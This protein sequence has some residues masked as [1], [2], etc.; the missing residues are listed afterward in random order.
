MTDFDKKEDDNLG[1]FYMGRMRNPPEPRRIL[2]KGMLTGV[3]VFAFAAILWYAYPSGQEKFAKLDIPTITADKSAYKF[4]PENP[5]G[6]EVPHQ[7]STVFDPIDN[8][9]ADSSAIQKLGAPPEEPVDRDSILS[10]PPIEKKMERLNLDM[11]IKE[12]E[13]GTEKVV[14]KAEAL[15]EP[16]VEAKAE[17]KVE[18][19]AELKPE[20]KA[21]HP[22]IEAKPVKKPAVANAAKSPAAPPAPVISEQ[23]APVP[24]VVAPKVVAKPKETARV[25]L[26]KKT[27]APPLVATQIKPATKGGIYIQLGSYRDLGAAKAD[28][29][30]LQK[31]FPQSI[32]KMTMVT[33]R[34]DL[35]AKGVFHRLQAK[36]P[37]EDRAKQI[38]RV[39]KESGNPDCIIVR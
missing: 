38:C 29:T 23:L 25:E 16:K 12:V 30:K 2:P 28:W 27:E 39:L 21:E 31:K 35:G 20:A 4:K 11:Q 22:K 37:T 7:D 18:P 10:N 14:P 19:K 1:S 34:A 17:P 33:E 26:M 15:P 13:G 8:K 5:G 24:A 3:T 32:G 36:T 6:M 9:S